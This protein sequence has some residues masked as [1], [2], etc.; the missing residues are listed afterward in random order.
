MTRSVETR[1]GLEGIE[2]TDV[3]QRKMGIR[4]EQQQ[5]LDND[6]Q[7]L[8]VTVGSM[9]QVLPT[10]AMGIPTGNGESLELCAFLVGNKATGNALL[11]CLLDSQRM[12]LCSTT[13]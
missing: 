4:Y 11:P 13:P 5:E 6:W 9:I 8:I 1:N 2:M 3:F 7:Y 10:K 12:Q